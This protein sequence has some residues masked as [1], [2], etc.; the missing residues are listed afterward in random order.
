MSERAALGR[1]SGPRRL[2]LARSQAMA[3]RLGAGLRE[4]RKAAGQLQR[5]AAAK[6]GLSQPRYSEME[7]GLGADATLSTWAVAAGAVGEQL[8]AFLEHVPGASRPRD[9]EH[10]R[11]QQLV[12]RVAL[13]G[14]WQALPEMPIDPDAYRS[15]SVDVC[16]VRPDGREAA[17]VE[18]WDWFAD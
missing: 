11:R 13:G 8:V 17:V 3:V 6:A 9:Y 12:V 2:A 5:E 16:L 18:I 4:A 14:G 15:R 10:L 1:S 7:R